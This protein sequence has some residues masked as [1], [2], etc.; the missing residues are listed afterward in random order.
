MATVQDPTHPTGVATTGDA[1]E[2]EA[3]TARQ[4]KEDAAL[5]LRM[6]DKEATTTELRLGAYEWDDIARILGYPSPR[7]AQVAYEKALQRNLHDDDRS[8]AKMRDLAG[9]RFERLMRA[10]WSKALD[11]DHPEQMAAQDRARAAIIEHARLYGL[12]APTE[13]VVSTPT[14]NELQNYVSRVVSVANAQLEEDDILDA[15]VV[16]DE[17]RE[18][19]A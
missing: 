19:G 15:D 13:M 1:H 16:E 11:P 17:T 6:G 3:K 10:V 2:A 18:I 7:A 8:T 4:R 14:D 9:R 12:H 5:A